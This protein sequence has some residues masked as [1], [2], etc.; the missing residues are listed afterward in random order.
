[1]WIMGAVGVSLVV[2]AV[3]GVRLNASVSRMIRE[4][5]APAGD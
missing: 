5:S 2:M 1:V 4:A 3:L